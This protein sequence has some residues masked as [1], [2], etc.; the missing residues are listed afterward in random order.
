[1]QRLSP[2]RRPWQ[3]EADPATEISGALE[4]DLSEILLVHPGSPPTA[5]DF[6][7]DPHSGDKNPKDMEKLWNWA[8][9]V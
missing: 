5:P 3:I 1:M 4:D 8:I 7:Q 2:Q 9:G 6:S